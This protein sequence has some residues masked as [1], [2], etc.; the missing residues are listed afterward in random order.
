V[1]SDEVVPT[2]FAVAQQIASKSPAVV[3][4]LKQSLNAT[5]GIDEL[6]KRY[7]QELSYTYELN[8]LGEAH[9]LRETFV[10]GRRSGYLRGK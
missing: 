8:L 6:R 10:D 1:P 5:A 3:R 9:D 4:R 2:A 7:R